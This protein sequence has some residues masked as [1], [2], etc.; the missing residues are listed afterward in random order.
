MTAN[1]GRIW[2]VL[3]LIFV[4]LVVLPAT[5][6]ARDPDGSYKRFNP[7]LHAWFDALKNREHGPCCS[8]ADGQSIA[9][10]DWGTQDR[11][12]THYWVI[13]DGEKTDVPDEALVD[14]PNRFGPAVVWVYQGYTY[15]Y[16]HPTG[17]VAKKMIRC[18][19]PGAM[20]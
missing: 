16:A 13:L 11:A 4:L 20:T 3:A 5:V 6:L 15:D 12:G 8:Y 19:M 18:F 17:G 7:Q 9:V 2:M 14:D 10:E 1:V